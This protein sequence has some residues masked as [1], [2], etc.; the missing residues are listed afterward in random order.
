MQL[1][2]DLVINLLLGLYGVTG[3]LG[4]SIILF[5][6]L[7]RSILLPISLGSLKSAH[8]LK[9]LQPEFKKIQKKHKDDKEALQKAQVELYQKYNV[10]PLAS[11]L[12]QIVQLVLLILLYRIFINFLNVEVLADGLDPSFLWLNLTQPDSTFILPVI[13]GVSQLFFSFMI[14]PGGEVRDLVPNESK[15]K[16]VQ[17]ENKK[18][19]GTADMAASMQK[20]MMFIMPFMTFFIALRFPSGL[21][22]YWVITTLFSIGQQAYISGWGGLISYP[23]QGLAWVQSKMQ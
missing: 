9:E 15:N 17:A 19:E 6:V 3:D 5:T 11:C 1:I 2:T 22:L 18:E 7:V 10:N 8:K 12:P 16:K 13:A 20:Q 14:M 23:K 21:A 4:V